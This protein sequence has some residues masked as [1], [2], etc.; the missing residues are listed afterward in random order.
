[1][2]AQTRSHGWFGPTRPT[3]AIEVAARRVTVASVS[4]SG[5]R[6]RAVVSAHAS[7]PLPD[8][9]VV[10]A[11]SGRN[12]PGRDEILAAL[13][14]ALDQ[15]GLRSARRAALIVPDTVARV[16]LVD[17]EEVP[18]RPADLDRLLRWQLR[19]SLPFPI[20]EARMSH[21]V[22][23]AD[24]GRVTLAVVLA[25]RDVLAEYE[26]LA[27]NLDIQAGIVDLASFN[28]ANAVLSSGVP[29]G[30]S[31][32]VCLAP[33]A[34]T[35][36]ILRGEQLMFYRHRATA[37]DEPISTLVHQ[38]AMFHVDRLA[39]TTFDRVWLAGVSENP[40]EVTRFSAEIAERLGVPVEPVDVRKLASFKTATLTPAEIDSLAASV[41]VILREARAA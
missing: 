11:L 14:R 37:G 15:A 16:S 41:G 34:T 39:G 18:A 35:L 21:L 7:A 19:K 36:L 28:V 13:R 26:S 10:P 38:A 24:A 5:G 1:M 12:L 27:A 31:L 23:H 9:A 20:D 25:R 32:L 3:V 6:G 30:D 29:S 22:A 33:E 2:S 8:G 4:A 17:L 40:G